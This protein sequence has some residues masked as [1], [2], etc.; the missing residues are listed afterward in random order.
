MS[1]ISKIEISFQLRTGFDLPSRGVPCQK[2]EQT[3]LHSKSDESK[4]EPSPRPL[5]PRT[6]NQPL[7]RSHVGYATA[8][9]RANVW[10]YGLCLAIAPHVPVG[11]SGGRDFIQSEI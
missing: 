2:G 4:K 8:N 10:M 5:L 9:G 1:T 3:P 7:R 11:N 6:R